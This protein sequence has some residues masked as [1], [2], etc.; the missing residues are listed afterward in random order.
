MGKNRESYRKGHLGGQGLIPTILFNHRSFQYRA[1]FPP[2]FLIPEKKDPCKEWGSFPKNMD[3]KILGLLFGV[4][5]QNQNVMLLSFY[6]G[7]PLL[8]GKPKPFWGI[9]DTAMLWRFSGATFSGPHKGGKADKGGGPI[10]WL[11]QRNGLAF[12]FFF[13]ARKQGWFQ[14]KP[15]FDQLRHLVRDPRK[16]EPPIWVDSNFAVGCL[17][18][19]THLEDLRLSLNGEGVPQLVVVALWFPL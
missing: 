11:K 15:N 4:P 16:E 14:G 13:C 19:A 1:L 12:W 6:S 8:V 3:G 9:Q 7:S 10:R 5:R 18:V 17:L 2:G